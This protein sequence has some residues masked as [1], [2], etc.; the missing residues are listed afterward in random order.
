M[1]IVG[2][3]MHLA[4]LFEIFEY[5]PT[6]FMR[7]KDIDSCHIIYAIHEQAATLKRLMSSPIL[8]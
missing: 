2:A 6:Q 8:V 4:I 7:L 3:M 1:M 5:L